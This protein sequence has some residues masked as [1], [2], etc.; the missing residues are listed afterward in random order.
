MPLR[1]VYDGLRLACV[2]R[3]DLI[4]QRQLLVEIKSIEQIHP[5]HHSQVMT[6]LRL[7]GVPQGLLINFNTRRLVDGLKSFLMAQPGPEP[8]A[9]NA[10]MEE[11]AGQERQA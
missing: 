8:N 3:A 4:V 6:Y 5:V 11:Q 7:A 10:G 2:Y 9:G 1:L